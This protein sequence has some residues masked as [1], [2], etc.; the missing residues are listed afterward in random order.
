M[1]YLCL[2]FILINFL[3]V[4]LYGQYIIAVGGGDPLCEGHQIDTVAYYHIQVKY[5]LKFMPDTMIRDN[6]DRRITISNLSPEGISSYCEYSKFKR[7]SI[8]APYFENGKIRLSIV[9]KAIKYGGRVYDDFYIVKSWPQ[10]NQLLYKGLAGIDGNFKYTEDIPDFN[11]NID[12]NRT[13]EIAN[14]KCH[15]AKGSYGGREYYAWFTTDIPIN[16]GPW[17]FWGL[18]GLIL[19]VASLDDEF[20]YTCMSIQKAEGPIVVEGLDTA[21]PTTKDRFL[22]VLKRHKENPTAGIAAM[23]DAGK[24]Q[25]EMN[26]KKQKTRAYNPQE[27][28]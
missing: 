24:L 11:W 1:K 19:E 17:K 7:D 8:K 4:H 13:K 10:R 2:I 21:I 15:F 3:P 9:N 16:N 22:K 6:Y 5:E 27:K 23:I 12:F 18:P 14:Y 26:L 20:I 28:Y 25:S